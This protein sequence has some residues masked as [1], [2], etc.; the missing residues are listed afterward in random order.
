MERTVWV[1]VWW[2]LEVGIT[3]E[4]VLAAGAKGSV[5]W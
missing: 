5:E 4:T 2:G 3:R 1:R